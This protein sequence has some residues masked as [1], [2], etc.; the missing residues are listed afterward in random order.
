MLNSKTLILDNNSNLT[1]QQEKGDLFGEE[2]NISGIV[3]SDK[4]TIYNINLTY[5]LAYVGGLSFKST[6]GIGIGIGK[7]QHFGKSAKE[8]TY[9]FQYLRNSYYYAVGIYAQMNSYR[10]KERLG[11]TSILTTGL[12]YINGK[13]IP[14]CFDPGG[15]S[16]GDCD[17]IKIKGFFPNIAIGCGYSIMLSV[18]SR[19]LIYLD[20][21]IKKNI[22]NLNIKI[23][24]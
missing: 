16:S 14:F 24:F 3:K 9:N 1:L 22:S 19:M 11:F 12:D 6:P 20:L 4:S 17:L 18:N 7:I 10:N 15:P 2:T 13:E 23:S 21:G 8:I 5:G